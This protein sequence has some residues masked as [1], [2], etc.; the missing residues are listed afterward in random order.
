MLK[1]KFLM[2]DM[3]SMYG[4]CVNKYIKFL[5]KFERKNINLWEIFWVM[6]SMYS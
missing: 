2:V 3:I 1:I 5:W 4:V 6:F